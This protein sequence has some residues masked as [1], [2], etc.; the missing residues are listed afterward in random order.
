MRKPEGKNPSGSAC[1]KTFDTLRET[2][3][4]EFRSRNFHSASLRYRC[5]V[6]RSPRVAISRRLYSAMPRL[7]NRLIFGI[8]SKKRTFFRPF[9]PADFCIQSP[10]KMVWAFIDGLNRREKSLRLMR[11]HFTAP[12]SGTRPRRRFRPGSH[13]FRPRKTAAMRPCRWCRPPA[14]RI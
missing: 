13:P 14:S 10:P 9:L 5:A 6:A 7:R 4:K 3:K 12:A 11:I 8:K 1:Q 2:A